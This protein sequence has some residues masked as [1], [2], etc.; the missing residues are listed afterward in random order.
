M[1]DKLEKKLRTRERCVREILSTEEVYVDRLRTLGDVF[2]GPLLADESPVT[3]KEQARKIFGN[4]EIIF[5]LNLRFLND[6]RSRIDSEE[7]DVTSTPIGD[8]FV[9]FGPFL[10]MYKEYVNGHDEASTILKTLRENNSKFERW[11]AEMEARPACGGLSL[12]AYLIEPIQRIP[13]Y[14]LLLQEV[15]K[16][17]VDSHPDM[18]ALE[19][20]LGQIKEVGA[21][22]NEQ[23]REREN[24]DKIRT[25]QSQFQGTVVFVAPGRRLVRQGTLTKQCRSFDRAYEFI[26]FN[27]L[28]CYASLNKLG[29]LKLHREMPIDD[30]FVVQETASGSVR[31]ADDDDE[32]GEAGKKGGFLRGRKTAVK[33]QNSFTIISAS[34]SFVVYT[35]TRGERDEWLNALHSVVRERRGTQRQRGNLPGSRDSHLAPVWQS[36][37]SS[38]NCTLCNAKFSL[39]FRRHHCRMCGALVCNDCSKSRAEIK[40]NKKPVRICDRCVRLVMEQQGEQKPALADSEAGST[41]SSRSVRARALFDHEA[42]T[43]AEISFKKGDEVEVQQQDGDFWFGRHVPSDQCGTFPASLVQVVADESTPQQGYD[44]SDYDLPDAKVGDTL[45]ARSAFTGDGDGELSFEA[46]D[47]LIL[48][49]KHESGWWLGEHTTSGKSGWF[50]PEYTAKA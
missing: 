1:S 39:V 5:G 36:D 26:L 21:W 19:E 12:E 2:R 40:G 27:D 24:R 6:L 42:A 33:T 30:N 8:I 45:V 50:S 43:P 46:G 34:K 49:D 28:L 44:L 13:R 14:R 3:D 16:N 29:Q 23:V 7:F 35:E 17:T 31:D 22:I 4:V 41:S 47:K 37:H 20:A 10:K 18:P 15:I 25:L 38:K 9:Q 11:V 48:R 32:D